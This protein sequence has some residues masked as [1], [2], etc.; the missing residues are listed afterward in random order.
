MITHLICRFWRW[1]SIV[2]GLWF[3][4]FNRS[5]LTQWHIVRQNLCIL[6]TLN[7]SYV[8]WRLAIT[9]TYFSCL[10]AICGRQRKRFV[11]CE[12]IKR[13]LVS[14]ISLVRKFVIILT[15]NLFSKV[16]LYLCHRCRLK[17]ASCNVIFCSRV[18]LLL[19]LLCERRLLSCKL[20]SAYCCC[21]ANLKI[22]LNWWLLNCSLSHF[23]WILCKSY[24]RFCICGFWRQFC[25]LWIQKL[26]F[27][28][29]FKFSVLLFLLLLHGKRLTTTNLMLEFDRV[30]I[31]SLSLP[32]FFNLGQSV[33]DLSL[34][35]FF[36]K[37]FDLTLCDD[38]LHSLHTTFFCLLCILHI[39]VLLV[40]SIDILFKLLLLRLLKSTFLILSLQCLRDDK[41]RIIATKKSIVE[42]WARIVDARC[43][44][45]ATKALTFKHWSIEKLADGWDI[46]LA[47]HT[48]ILSPLM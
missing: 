10:Y 4:F 35:H 24:R 17:L 38:F 39:L 44:T 31:L 26:G 12:H 23:F 22:V 18:A 1:C 37:I 8:S 45:C 28:L 14:V 34:F 9:Q 47:D 27:K 5:T 42:T 3:N 40:S 6:N 13:L 20:A 7:V 21:C 19:C 15:I 46:S 30:W 32:D 48:R 29:L 25:W 11:V 2:E 43:K 41:S 33:L 16:V 36:F